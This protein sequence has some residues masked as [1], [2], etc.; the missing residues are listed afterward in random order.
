MRARTGSVT[1]SRWMHPERIGAGGAK[2]REPGVAVG[3]LALYLDR[4]IDRRFHRGGALG[5]NG[6]AAI[7]S[8]WGAGGHHHVL[9]A[10]EFDGGFGHFGKLRRRLSLDR[11]ASGE[12]LAD[13]AELAGLGAALISNTGLEN[14]S[15]EHVASMQ[16]GDLRIGYAVGSLQR[17]ESRS[18]RKRR[19]ADEQ[20]VAHDPAA[21]V[22]VGLLHQI[23]AFEGRG[24]MNRR[25]HRH[26]I[27]RDRLVIGRTG[28]AAPAIDPGLGINQP[29]SVGLQ[30]VDQQLGRQD[31]SHR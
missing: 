16:N 4:Q 9:D 1:A 12:R 5:Q 15:G 13:R 24:R 14:C 8:R 21:P 3:R 17:V 18:L 10:V 2:A 28:A 6:R 30:L 31:L 19:L 27:D 22:G 25:H 11:A 23:G 26:A 20:T 29:H 7:L